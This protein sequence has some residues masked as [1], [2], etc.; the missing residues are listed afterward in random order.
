MQIPELL[1]QRQ[2]CFSKMPRPQTAQNCGSYGFDARIN[3][4][5]EMYF[6]HQ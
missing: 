6:S 3:I 5:T 4:L 2:F 1:A